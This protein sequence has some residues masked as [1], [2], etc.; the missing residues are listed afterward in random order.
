[1]DPNY[2][3]PV[4]KKVDCGAPDYKKDNNCDDNNNL[5]SCDWDGGDCCGPNIGTTYCTEVT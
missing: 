5:Q 4:K 1:M 3:A 2:V